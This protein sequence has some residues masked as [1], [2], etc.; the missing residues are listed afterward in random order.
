MQERPHTWV[1]TTSLSSHL[2]IYI[3][4]YIGGAFLLCSSQEVA[5][6][7]VFR[8]VFFVGCGTAVFEGFYNLHF[9]SHYDYYLCMLVSLS[10]K[11]K[12]QK[13]TFLLDLI[14]FIKLSI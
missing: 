9:Y 8:K 7:T 5:E 11:K 3:Y 14:S 6:L 4:I 10:F 1:R 12:K 2:Y 13:K